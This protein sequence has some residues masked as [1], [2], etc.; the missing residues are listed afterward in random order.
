MNNLDLLQ[1][2]KRI[3]KSQ[4]SDAECVAFV[5]LTCGGDNSGHPVIY[6]SD[7]IFLSVEIMISMVTENADLTGKPKL[8]FM[9][10]NPCTREL[11]R[12]NPGGEM[13][14]AGFHRGGD[15]GVDVDPKKAQAAD[16]FLYYVNL[17]NGEF[18]PIG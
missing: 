14:S 17:E 13:K 8:F 18:L 16:I 5:V 11:F 9:V 15:D 6:G 3:K 2:L 1:K 4:L 7:A 10:L 12:A